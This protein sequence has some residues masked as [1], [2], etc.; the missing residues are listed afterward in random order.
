MH[1][2]AKFLITMISLPPLSYILF[3][4]YVIAIDSYDN[5]IARE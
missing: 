3:I 4:Q 2:S 1:F 5:S